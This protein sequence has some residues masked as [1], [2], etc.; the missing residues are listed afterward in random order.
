M[1]SGRKLAKAHAVRGLTEQAAC[2]TSSACVATYTAV[3][4]RGV[5]NLLRRHIAV[6]V[7]GSS[8]GYSL[9]FYLPAPEQAFQL[10]GIEIKKSFRPTIK[11]AANYIF[12]YYSFERHVENFI[13]A[14]RIT[15]IC[16]VTGAIY[17]YFYLQIK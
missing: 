7:R 1:K 11:N 5:V 12:M 16:N 14:W 10:I 6:A 15:K 13:G 17:C 9:Q 8:R 4:Y 2:P 3:S